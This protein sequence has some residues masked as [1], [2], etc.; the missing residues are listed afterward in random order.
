M[1][2]KMKTKDEEY[3]FKIILKS[4]G[5]VLLIGIIIGLC[6]ATDKLITSQKPPIEGLDYGVGPRGGHWHLTSGGNKSYY[7][8]LYGSTRNSNG[9]TNIAFGVFLAVIVGLLIMALIYLIVLLGLDV[10]KKRSGVVNV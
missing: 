2:L 5:I 6:F 9:R 4:I 1:G 3:L 7:R 8:P 10:R